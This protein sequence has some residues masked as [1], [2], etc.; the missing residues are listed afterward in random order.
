MSEVVIRVRPNGPYVIEGPVKVLDSQGNAFPTV[1]GKAIA[2][3]RCGQS[4]NKPFCDGA[5]RTCN[6]TAADLASA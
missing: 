6:F 5:H 1:E 4:M 3:C 2:L